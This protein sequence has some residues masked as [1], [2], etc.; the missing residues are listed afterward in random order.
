MISV[1]VTVQRMATIHVGLPWLVT[2][3]LVTPAS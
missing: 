2:A 1:S 3:Q